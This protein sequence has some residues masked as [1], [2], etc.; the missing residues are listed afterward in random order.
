[1]FV[2]IIFLHYM[3]NL[4]IRSDHLGSASSVLWFYLKLNAEFY[5]TAVN[6]RCLSFV[7]LFSEIL[8]AY[9]S[10]VSQH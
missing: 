1:M 3:R 2:V 5:K 6:V 7:Q 8:T 9:K 4:R 10:F